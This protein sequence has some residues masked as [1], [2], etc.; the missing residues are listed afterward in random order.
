[1][2]WLLRR[3]GQEKANGGM[4]LEGNAMV[5]PWGRGAERIV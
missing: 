4:F 1:M 2:V 3:G 5:A